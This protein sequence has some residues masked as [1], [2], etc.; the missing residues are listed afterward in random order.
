MVIL[1]LILQIVDY[2]NV[3][4]LHL[5]LKAGFNL[6]LVM[7]LQLSGWD[8]G[9][10]FL[11]HSLDGST[12]AL[13]WWGNTSEYWRASGQQC[14]SL[15]SCDASVVCRWPVVKVE[16]WVQRTECSTSREVKW[17]CGWRYSTSLRNSGSWMVRRSDSLRLPTAYIHSDKVLYDTEQ[18]N[19]TVCVSHL[20]LAHVK[21]QVWDGCSHWSIGR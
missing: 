19:I 18:Q 12:I 11:I 2:Q 16:W 5:Y 17:T 15:Q 20:F 14:L 1:H 10:L 7:R 9:P 8:S 13:V 21:G 6:H 4:S 3:L